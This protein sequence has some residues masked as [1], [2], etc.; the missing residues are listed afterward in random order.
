MLQTCVFLFF[1]SR[2]TVAFRTKKANLKVINSRIGWRA[3]EKELARVI[4]M[5]KM[6]SHN[7]TGSFPVL[8][9]L[10]RT[11]FDFISFTH[12]YATNFLNLLHEIY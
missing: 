10:V 3:D 5:I 8:T 6:L 12:G 7:T 9:H 1:A 4:R 2:Q 11:I